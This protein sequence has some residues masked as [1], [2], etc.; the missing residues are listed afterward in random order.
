MNA[1][2]PNDVRPILVF[3]THNPNKVRELQEMLGDQYQ[4]HCID[5]VNYCC[6]S[7]IVYVG[8]G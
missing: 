5:K 3:A 1:D 6:T 4:I 8:L 7:H 2:H